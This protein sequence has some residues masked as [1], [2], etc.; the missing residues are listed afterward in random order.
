M[1]KRIFIAAAL[2]VCLAPVHA[3][4][5]SWTDA[6][7]TR[8]Y[9]DAYAAPATAAPVKMRVPQASASA[10]SDKAATVSAPSETTANAPDPASQSEA[11]AC[12][13]ARNNKTLLGDSG[14]DVLSEDGK[15]VLDPDAR[16]Q[17]LALADKRVQ[18]YCNVLGEGE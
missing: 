9:G 14:K 6:Q 2:L 3:Q 12:R 18:A 13:V 17:R 7:G 1:N 8:H 16:A 5:Y 11:D 15:T 10:G 4:V